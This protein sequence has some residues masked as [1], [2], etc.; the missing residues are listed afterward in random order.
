M[1]PRGVALLLTLA[2][3]SG[4]AAKAQVHHK[5]GSRPVQELRRDLGRIFGAP[6]MARVPSTSRYCGWSSSKRPFSR[7]WS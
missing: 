3:S 5:P 2:L 1:H 4:C 6:V 7:P